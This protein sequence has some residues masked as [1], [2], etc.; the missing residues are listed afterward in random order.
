[1]NSGLI[2]IQ[3]S[4]R[5]I[6]VLVMAVVSVTPV[7]GTFAQTITNTPESGSIE[8][9]NRLT[10]EEKIGQ[11]FLI[12]F[13]GTD[14]GPESAIYGL[15]ANHHIG[16][17]IIL[18][19]N[20]NLTHISQSPE[21]TT[22]QLRSMTRKLQ[23]IEWTSSQQT[24][25]EP[26]TEESFLPAYIPLLIA[27]P[28]EGDGF[29]Y[30]QVLYG[31]TQ[32]PNLMA[33]GATWNSELAGEIGKILGNELASLGI[34]LLIGPSLD[35]LESP[36]TDDTQDLGTRTFGGDPYWVSELGRN[37]IQGIHVGSEGKVAVVSKHFP[38]HGGADRL[39]EDEV[40]TV[41]KTMD[42]LISFDLEPFFNTTGDARAQEETTD[43]LLTSHIRYQGLQGN[44]RATTR[45]VSLDPQ[46]LNLLLELPEL[47][48]WRQ[49]G[50]VLISDNLSSQ[51]IRR[52]YD[53]T[54]QDF[55]IRRV[56]LNAF[57]AGNDILYISDFTSIEEEDLSTATIQTLEFFA[58]KY[59]EDNAFA[60]R[61]DESVLRILNL[62]QKLFKDFSLNRVI[63]FPLVPSVVEE[64]QQMVFEVARQGATLISPS[65]IELDETIPDPPNQND[66][67]VFISDTRE[68]RQCSQCVE[69][70]LLGE[71][72]LQEFVTRRYG[73]Q[74]GGQVSP[75]NLSSYS[76]TDLQELLDGS[77]NVSQLELDLKRTNWVVFSM[78]DNDQEYGAYT[79]LNQF[80]DERPDLFQQKRLIVFSFNAPYFM[81]ATNISKLTAFYTLYSKTPQFIDLASYLL[82]REIQPAGSSP[83]SVS[84]INYDLN[85]VLFPD[86]D[87]VIP[88][89][90][91]IDQE[92]LVDIQT[93]PEPQPDPE[94]NVGD[95]IPLKT[96]VILDHNGNPV[97]DGTPVDFVQALVGEVSST[98]QTET[99]KNGIAET[100]FSVS[101]PG[102]LEFYA[103][104]EQASSDILR[105]D[106]PSPGNG[107]T[108][109]PQQ[110]ENAIASSPSPTDV[111]IPSNDLPVE[112]AEITN[113]TKIGDWL[114]AILIVF[115][116]SWA[117][118][119]L[120][121]LVGNVRW[122]MRTSL[123]AL[124]G[125]LLAYSIL[126][127]QIPKNESYILGSI[128]RSVILFTVIG[129]FTGILITIF[130][131]S[132][133]ERLI[134]NK[135]SK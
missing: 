93:T 68:A 107:I 39:P 13:E 28:Q 63:E 72:S 38:G 69:Q 34:N 81:D 121:A 26:N 18:A 8:I 59:R 15:I 119:R 76:I 71:K 86:P 12:A 1:M 31:I 19:E 118:F 20:D 84:G 77:T 30:D 130:W 125:G 27:M 87:Q 111:A 44:I 10:P 91:N 105:I 120:S 122:G 116:I 117:V 97:P 57:L 17:V 127:Y 41:R 98:R 90:I 83:V 109:T 64:P 29:A 102:T 51:A 25:N 115:G 33:L 129:A 47:D 6:I 108:P 112:E 58:Q 22:R 66:R 101:A 52:F 45:P 2:L 42:D 24:L 103:E 48:L 110:T 23:Q 74:A 37:Y 21:E 73:P 133:S 35:I 80:L 82:F 56:A 14:V 85:N 106:I 65:E 114:I 16:N 104:S 79:I 62:K 99:T 32:L 60:Q 50:G 132:I 61:V 36:E 100:T 9:L 113:H 75:F 96:G 124:V 126:A 134:K 5:V 135:K 123:L 46:A 11:L 78:L 67:I 4:I 55:D 3:K 94:F 40:A 88:L 49:N 92:G 89:M 95:V 70:P 7:V 54:N 53:L 128:S 43:A 131:R